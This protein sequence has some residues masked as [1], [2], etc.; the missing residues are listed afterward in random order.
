MDYV[1]V[2]ALYASILHS[3]NRGSKNHLNW[4]TWCGIK[5][6][7]NR[8]EEKYLEKKAMII[9]KAKKKEDSKKT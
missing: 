5:T 4:V 3:E 6:E 2:N 9:R 7:K 8:K 1:S